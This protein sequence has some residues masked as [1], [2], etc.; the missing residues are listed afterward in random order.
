MTEIIK[1]NWYSDGDSLKLSMPIAKVDKE[2]RLVSG[3]ATLDNIDQHGDIVAA[4]ASTKAFENFRGNIREMHTPLAVGKKYHS[5]KKLYSIRRAG[6][7]TAE[8]L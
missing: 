4:E 5:V 3:F 1:S 7:S 6:K 2:R 8:Y